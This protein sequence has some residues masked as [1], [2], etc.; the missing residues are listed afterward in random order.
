MLHIHEVR[1]EHVD[2]HPKV[3][4]EISGW[5]W[6]SQKIILLVQAFSEVLLAGHSMERGIK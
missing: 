3:G 6:I 1:G 2:A 5:L 4:V